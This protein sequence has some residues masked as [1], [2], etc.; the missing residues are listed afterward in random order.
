[1]DK[2]KLVD[3][4]DFSAYFDIK[5]EDVADIDYKICPKCNIQMSF[6]ITNEYICQECGLSKG[7]ITATDDYNMASGNSYNTL[8]SSSTP[9]KCVGTNSFK[10]QCLLRNNSSYSVIQENHIKTTLFRLN[11]N[12]CNELNIP[13]DILLSVNE[14]YKSIRKSNNIYRG[15]ILK[16]ILAALTYY[17]C[18]RQGLTHKPK[19][20]SSWF[21]IDSNNLSKGEKIVRSLIEEGIIDLKLEEIETKIDNSFIESYSKRIGLNASY[22]PFLHELLEEVD[23]QRIVNLNSKSSTKA[24]SL[25]YLV[26]V[27]KKIPITQDDLYEEFKISRS[28]FKQMTNS[29]LKHCD[30]LT[31]VFEK[32]DIPKIYAVPRVSKPRAKKNKDASSKLEK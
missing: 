27:C 26:I 17:E 31:C 6:K 18:L 4:D 12:N 24:I 7:N 1:M 32:Y 20:I 14:Q 11:Y 16:G 15:Q 19:E 30:L 8:N 25:I 22:L 5:E 28:T 10:F 9:L 23:R 29:I 2:F 21:N 3:F 13:K